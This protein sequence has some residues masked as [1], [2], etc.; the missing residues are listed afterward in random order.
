VQCVRSGRRLCF[1]IFVSANFLVGVTFI[2]DVFFTILCD[3]SD[4]LSKGW[5]ELE[6][7]QPT[8]TEPLH[9]PLTE[10]GWADPVPWALALEDPAS[11]WESCLWT[12]CQGCW[13]ESFLNL[14]KKVQPAW[15]VTETT[16]LPRKNQSWAED[17]SVSAV[18]ATASCC[19][20]RKFVPSH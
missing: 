2:D 3:T 20:G 17:L 11:L 14:S 16:H 15:G 7:M 18:F 19:R 1:S 5:V 4:V 8:C 6:T 13:P 12:V 10:L 9:V